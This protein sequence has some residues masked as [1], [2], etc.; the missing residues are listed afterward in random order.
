[1]GAE[2]DLVEKIILGRK[3]K[4]DHKTSRPVDQLQAR[5]QDLTRG[6]SKNFAE[7]PRKFPGI[8]HRKIQ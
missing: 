3:K 1:M 6:P 7:N 8:F 4:K 2:Y 5:S